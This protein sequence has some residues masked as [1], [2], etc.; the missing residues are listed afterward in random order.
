MP[1]SRELDVSLMCTAPVRIVRAATKASSR[2]LVNTPAA[3]PKRIALMPAT[4]SCRPATGR[5][6]STGAK[7]SSSITFMPERTPVSSVAGMTAPTR[8]PP[9]AMRACPTLASASHRS[10]R[11]AS[12]TLIIGPM[13]VAG[14]RGSPAGMARAASVSRSATSSATARSTYSRCTEVHTCPALRKDAR[15]IFGIAASRSALAHTT[16]DAMLPSSS[17]VPRSPAPACTM[18]PTRV[19]PVKV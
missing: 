7:I 5:I 11:S 8:V 13:R 19:L 12:A 2:S 3:R 15:A 16:V 4:A 14:S 10:A 6:E 17:C 9:Q 1:S 18:R